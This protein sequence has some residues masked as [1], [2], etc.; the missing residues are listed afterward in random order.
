[1][2]FPH[3]AIEYQEMARDAMLER[4]WP[5]A[6]AILR[7]IRDLAAQGY[8]GHRLVYFCITTDCQRFGEWYSRSPWQEPP[9]QCLECG[10]S[11]WPVFDV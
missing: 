5:D 8:R 1:M 6:W 10:A 3:E 4:K 11:P 7:Q 2:K 9:T